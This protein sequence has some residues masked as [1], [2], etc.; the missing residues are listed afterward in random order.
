[1]TNKR[2]Y[3]GIITKTRDCWWELKNVVR[4]PRE[5]ERER[6]RERERLN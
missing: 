5:L 1:M 2:N 4:E 6:E 3:S